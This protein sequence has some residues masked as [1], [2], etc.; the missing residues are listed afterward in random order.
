MIIRSIELTNFRNFEYKRIDF[1][2][3]VN[4]IFGFNGQ[5]KTN[6]L[7]AI[8]VACLCKSFRTRIDADLIQQDKNYFFILLQVLLDNEVEKKI[9]VD[10]NRTSGKQIEIDNSKINSVL[11]HF[12]TFPIV[13]LSPEDDVITIGP[14]V[15]RRKFLNFVL[16]QVDKEYLNLIHDY[17]KIIKQR[18]KILQ[19][20]KESRYKFSEKIEPWN[21]SLFALSKKITIKRRDF[22]NYIEKVVQPIHEELTIYLEKFTF[23]YKSSFQ[24]SWDNY[25]LYKK[26]LNK[27]IN[28]EIIRGK[29]LIGPHK[30]DMIFS[31]NGF[32]LRKYGSRGQHRTLLLALKIAIYKILLE[33]RKETPV[34]LLDDVYSEIDDV[35][36]K[37]FNDY[38]LDLKQVFITTHNKN[39]KFDLPE[40]YSKKINYIL[41]ENNNLNSDHVLS[42]I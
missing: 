19:E 36:E 8:S 25:E 40:D 18:N 42:N 30:D 2:N 32:D 9:K 41:I 37:A 13:V 20:A 27:I 11:E 29:T 5:G 39:T 31:L 38:F 10:Y 24:I 21:E 28:E 33:K 6:I 35:R 7:E 34:F 23:N 4:V 1:H 15:E 14:P 26:N 17:Q 12:G 3:A 16:A 22:L